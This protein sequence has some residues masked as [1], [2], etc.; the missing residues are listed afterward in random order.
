MNQLLAGGITILIALIVWSSKSKKN[1][2][3]FNTKSSNYHYRPQQQESSLVKSIEPTIKTEES[4]SFQSS[5]ENFQEPKTAKEINLL[6][7]KLSKLISGNPNDR[8]KAIKIAS[9]W[10]NVR[11]I[12]ILKRG[13]KDSESLIMI[14]SAEAMNNYRGKTNK[15]NPKVQESRPPRNVSLMR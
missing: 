13:L 1:N 11:S 12:P 15:Q 10:K 6:K 9:K 4:N 14:A 2:L 8:L 5:S 7:V 3:E